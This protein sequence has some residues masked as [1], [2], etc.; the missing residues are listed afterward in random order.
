MQIEG[1]V[2]ANLI[3]AVASARR[4]RGR[5]V[6]KDTIDHWRRLLD[7]GRQVEGEPSGEPVSD[8]V[9]ELEAEMQH[10]KAGQATR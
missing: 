3:A 4:W 9:A 2:R 8:L 1:S 10:I 6:H 7:H 5:P